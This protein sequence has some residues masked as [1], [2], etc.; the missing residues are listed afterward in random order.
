M[1]PLNYQTTECDCGLTTI[2]N[3]LLSLLGRS[4]FNLHLK[5]KIDLI[6]VDEPNF[7][8]TSRISMEH[9]G[10]II[11]KYTNIKAKYIKDMSLDELE[12]EL[13]YTDFSNTRV[14]LRTKYGIIED[15][16]HYILIVRVDELGIHIFDPYYVEGVTNSSRYYGIESNRYI[17]FEDL[18][19]KRTK[20]YGLYFEKDDVLFLSKII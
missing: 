10:S 13:K 9:I 15:D 5:N 18:K 8:G 7:H 17:K 1:Q 20:L 19:E 14:I 12:L 11:E 3:A 4:N 6:C 2:N 16:E